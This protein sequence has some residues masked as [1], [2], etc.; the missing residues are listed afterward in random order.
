MMG[1]W[2]FF[3]PS[4]EVKE[5]KPEKEKA[6][7][8]FLGWMSSLLKKKKDGPLSLN[9]SADQE[10]IK[11]KQELV[12]IPE[13][14]RAEA[15]QFISTKISEIEKS[16]EAFSPELGDEVSFRG[17]DKWYVSDIKNNGG[18]LEIRRSRRDPK[19]REVLEKNIVRLDEISLPKDG[20]AQEEVSSEEVAQENLAESFVNKFKLEEKVVFSGDSGWKVKSVAGNQVEIGRPIKDPLGR[21]SYESKIVSDAELEPDTSV[22]IPELK[23]GDGVI[24]NGETGWEIVSMADK[25]GKYLEVGKVRADKKGALVFERKIVEAKEVERKG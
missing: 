1:K 2:N 19:G 21:D 20:E 12:N 15:E 25:T 23:K 7:N 10:L 9:L 11:I 13:G 24:V 14:D 18:L 16:R 6:P 8:K 4:E 22:D 3:V 17:S 5:K